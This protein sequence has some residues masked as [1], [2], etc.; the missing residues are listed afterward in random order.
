ML[1]ATDERPPVADEVVVL[2]P[3]TRPVTVSVVATAGGSQLDAPG[4]TGVVIEPGRQATLPLVTLDRRGAA[5]VV[6][7]TA[8]VV[9]E[10]FTA[11]PWGV[12]APSGVP[13]FQ[14]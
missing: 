14:G 1:V 9:A 4:L 5:V 11:G 6:T 12:T 10:R 3:G 13:W 8:P 2:N 7:A